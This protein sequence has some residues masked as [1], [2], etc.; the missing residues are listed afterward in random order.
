ME[1]FSI[2]ITCMSSINV[3]TTENKYFKIIS[4]GFKFRYLLSG[5][6][7]IDLQATSLFKCSFD[8]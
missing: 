7:H 2:S 5:S 1:M 8:L 6:Q 4:L 3:F